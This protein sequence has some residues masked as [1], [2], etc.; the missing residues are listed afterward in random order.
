MLTM[1]LADAYYPELDR[2]KALRMA[3]LHDVGEVHAGDITPYHDVP[4]D[5]KKRRERESFIQ[6][7]GR[8]PGAERYLELWDEYERAESPESRF[9]HAM[10]RVELVLQ[11]TIYEHE[12]HG[13]SFDEFYEYIDSALGDPRLADIVEGIRAAR[14]TSTSG[15]QPDASATDRSY[16]IHG[17]HV[18]TNEFFADPRLIVDEHGREDG[19]IRLSVL[20][21]TGLPLSVIVVTAE[22]R[23]TPEDPEPFA[24]LGP[25]TVESWEP[26]YFAAGAQTFEFDMSYPEEIAA[27]ID[28]VSIAF[29]AVATEFQGV[30]DD[31]LVEGEGPA[32]LP[33]E[34]ADDE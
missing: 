4:R 18:N 14:R 6:V 22:V 16:E 27:I 7:L 25:V 26:P 9:V 10:D 20:N 32:P 2:L 28:D 11:A 21:G 30:E 17:R 15:E 19:R 5:E 3:L 29:I 34:G 12:G 24:L 31:D 13:G 1:L 23:Y 33:E 8:L